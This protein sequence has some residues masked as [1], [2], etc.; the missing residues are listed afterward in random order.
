MSTIS[1]G[2]NS[3]DGQTPREV[4]AQK[5]NQRDSDRGLAGVET[6]PFADPAKSGQ[7]EADDAE[8]SD[9][10][11]EENLISARRNAGRD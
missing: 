5:A 1:T 10:A 9:V 6:K 7:A 4:D 3:G 11:S 8:R 2:Q